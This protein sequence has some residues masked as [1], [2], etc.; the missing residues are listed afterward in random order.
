MKNNDC[1]GCGAC[2]NACTRQ[3]ISMQEDAKGFL[4]PQIDMNKC[5]N[6]G[7]CDKVCDRTNSDSLSHKALKAYYLKA[8]DKQVVRKST[9]GGAFTIL[10]DYILSQGGVIYGSI[11]TKDFCIVHTS[12]NT[13]EERDSMRGS[14]YVQSSIGNTFQSIKKNLQEGKK[15]LFVGTPCQTAGLKAYLYRDFDNLFII[16]M[17]CHGVPNNKMF[18]DHLKYI[19]GKEQASVDSYTF[20]NKSYTWRPGAVQEAVIRNKVTAS[21]DNQSFISFFSQNLSLRES[22]F[23]CK[24]RIPER[25]SDFT[26]ADFWDLEQIVGEKDTEG[27]SLVTANTPKAVTLL[28]NE[29]LGAVIKEVNYKDVAY[30]YAHRPLLDSGVN[31]D[32]FWA[33]YISKGYGAVVDKYYDNSLYRRVKFFIKKLVY[34]SK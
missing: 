2:M 29:N 7:L 27:V 9:S 19:E 22:C 24:H 33:T 12:A 4:Y 28:Q 18:K 11:M 8:S 26:I 34:K 14:K 10:S 21:F 32:E 23:N 20:R 25:Y 15:V 3:A 31:R 1:T 17:L 5:I 6:C 30:R 16:D 13:S